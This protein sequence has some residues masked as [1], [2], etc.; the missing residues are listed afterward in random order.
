MNHLLQVKKLSKNEKLKE[1]TKGLDRDQSLITKKYKF[2]NL[3]FIISKREDDWFGMV[4]MYYKTK[5]Y[6]KVDGFY[7]IISIVNNI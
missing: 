3:D 7:N 5:N 2:F 6:Y 4:V 1:G